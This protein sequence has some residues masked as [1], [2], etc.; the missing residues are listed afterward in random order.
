MFVL[1]ST[2]IID[3]MKSKEFEERIEKIV[4]DD[5]V[6][7]TT[8][9]I[10]EVMLGMKESEKN[11]AEDFFKSI[12]ILDFN[13]DASLRSVDIEKELTKKGAKINIVDIFIA[14][15]CASNRSKLITSDKKFGNISS[16]ESI[17]I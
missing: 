4:N 9:S 10:F 7:A 12:H 15:I 16:I 6:A 13:Q 17:V 3:I 14:G 8:F 11:I 1:D 2:I 5:I